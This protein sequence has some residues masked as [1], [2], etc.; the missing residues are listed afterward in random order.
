MKTERARL[1]IDQQK[2]EESQQ[3]N[4]RSLWQDTSDYILPMSSDITTSEYP[5][6]PRG[7]ELFD[8]TAIT[9]A[10]QMAAGLS[11]AL[12]PPGQ[13]FFEIGT[14][15]WSDS[16]N[17]ENRR[18]LALATE[19]THEELVQ[20]NF[21]EVLN[22][23]LI[24]DIVFGQLNMYSEF[25]NGGLNFKHHRA[26]MYQYLVGDEGR[27]HTMILKF[28]LTALQ[29]VKLWEDPG[30]SVLK[31]MEKPET[32]G[33]VFEFIH[34][35]RPRENRNPTLTDNMN[36]D[37]ESI[38]VNIKDIWEI[39]EGGFRLF[40][41]HVARWQ[42]ASNE[43]Y[44]R[45]IGTETLPQVKVLN[46]MMETFLELGDKLCR[47]PR[48]ILSSFEGDV[49]TT[50]DGENFVAEMGSI[51]A[52]DSGAIGNFATTEKMIEM[53]RDVIHKAFYKDV[54]APLTDLTGDRR[55][56]LEIRERIQEGLRRLGPPIG[57][58]WSEL[59][60]PMITRCIVLLYENGK[61]PPLPAELQ[62]RLK[63][64]Y[65]G[66]MANALKSG[67]A[68]AAREWIGL[69]TEMGASQMWPNVTDV[70]DIDAAVRRIGHSL[71][72]SIEDIASE[73]EVEAKR[74]ERAAAMQLQQQMQALEMAGKAYPG[75]TKAPEAG[76]P[77]EAL[78][79]AG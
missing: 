57:R 34:I 15:D 52:L 32:Q 44:G 71:G 17:D 18:H 6:V 55:T 76:S 49:D 65:K 66:S 48:E 26:G 20:S 53:Q 37:Y 5:G 36:M 70:V 75:A 40:P 67:E 31:A 64:E 21:I 63:I 73:D 16:G 38:Y 9:D 28:P 7:V 11:Q 58:I 1:I 43:K 79:G 24:G 25:K 13:H 19:I 59:F 56:T 74:A 29:A 60:D 23:A 61:I 3:A 72:V 2:R 8:I 68:L 33:K 14:V 62:G 54:F 10:Y 69:L 77:A 46:H 39:E 42:K 35:V 51:K 12:I 30:P 22:E 78:M 41:Y 27:V 45:G 4:F 50:P 47:P